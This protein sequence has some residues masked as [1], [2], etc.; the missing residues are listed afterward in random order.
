MAEP[1][2]ASKPRPT[3]LVLLHGV[4]QGPTAWQPVVDVIGMSRPVLAPWLRGL[5]PGR[6]EEFD[7]DAAA[8]A[9]AQTLQL[10]GYERVALVGSSLG[11]VVATRLAA[12]QPDLVERLLLAA[13]VIAPPRWA[14]AAQRGV[15]ALTPRRV[16]TDRGVTKDSVRTALAAVAALDLQGDLTRLTTPPLVVV[17]SGDTVGRQ[18]AAEIERRVRGTTR[19]ELA[20]A[21]PDL[22]RD[23][24]PAF[25]EV[26]AQWL[27]AANG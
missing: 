4:G 22:L 21:G 5:Q 15:L 19:R 23:A 17:G 18:A 11:A 24:G 26:V 16:F 6:Q 3:P 20:G 2:A 27:G 8:G 13:P 12:T 7:L 9:V 14:L 10:H 25:G 1:G